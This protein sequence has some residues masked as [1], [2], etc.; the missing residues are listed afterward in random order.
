MDTQ[1]KEQAAN[2]LVE[3]RDELQAELDL[4]NKAIQAI[5]GGEAPQ[6][7]KKQPVPGTGNDNS[8][9]WKRLPFQRAV[10]RCLQSK[11]NKAFRASEIGKFL[12]KKRAKGYERK[13]FGPMCATAVRRLVD[14]DK[15]T[16]TTVNINDRVVAA[17][18][19]KKQHYLL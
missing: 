1:K 17:F 8:L 2:L 15:A 11:P 6:N 13:S 4:I 3:H 18:K 16:K 14:I 7:P 9:D 10:L 19:F 5:M 12:K